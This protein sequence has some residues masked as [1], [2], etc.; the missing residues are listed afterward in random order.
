MRTSWVSP[1]ARYC[2]VLAGGEP[3]EYALYD[4]KEQRRAATLP[5]GAYPYEFRLGD[6][7][8][9]F[10]HGG[11]VRYLSLATGEIAAKLP[12][13]PDSA[14]LRIEDDS[15]VID[16]RSGELLTTLPR[17]SDYTAVPTRSVRC[18]T[19]PTNVLPN[20]LTS[21]PLAN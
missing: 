8:F 9:R 19:G 17:H 2:V 11:A 4:L 14:P 3:G 15:K 10:K 7:W 13:E 16:A 6:G 1:G 5:E 21:A 12:P 18:S 20:R